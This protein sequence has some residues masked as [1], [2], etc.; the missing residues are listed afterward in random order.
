[1]CASGICWGI[2]VYVSEKAPNNQHHHKPHIYTQ[3]QGRDAE[4]RGVFVFNLGRIDPGKGSLEAYQKMGAYLV[5]RFTRE[6][7]HGMH[8]C[9]GG[10]LLV[11]GYGCG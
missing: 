6:V 2:R 5:E 7:M 8:A 10:C 11:C 3:N 1:M 9:C 4:G